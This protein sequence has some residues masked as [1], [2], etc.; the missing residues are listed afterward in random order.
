MAILSISIS[1]LF[2][3]EARLVV[4]LGQPINTVMAENTNYRSLQCADLNAILK[5]KGFPYSNKRKEELIDLCESAEA[6]NLPTIGQIDDDLGASISRRTVKGKT[7]PDPRS[8]TQLDWT[9]NL[10]R[11][12]SIDA[13]DIAA[14][15]LNFCGW[16]TE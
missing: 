4:S 9:E 10:R 15:L 13:F 11:M 12:P 2:K 6:L 1:A 5:D 7:Y 3:L 16:S 14:Y 8:N